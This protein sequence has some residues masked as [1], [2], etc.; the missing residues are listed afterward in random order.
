[1]SMM[2]DRPT[3]LRA[4]HAP[5]FWAWVKKHTDGFIGRNENFARAEKRLKDFAAGGLMLYWRRQA[6]YLAAA[7]LCGTFYSLL[8]AILCYSLCQITELADTLASRRVLAWTNGNLDQCKKYYRL[9]MLTSTLSS[10]AVAVFVFAVAR[11]EGTSSHF[12]PLFFLFAA[13]LFA[14]VNNHQIPQILTVRLLVYGMLFI[15]IPLRDIYVMSA[16]FT[17]PQ[18]LQF[19]T[20]IFVLYFVLD[21]SFIFLKMYR[22][23]LDQLDEVRVQRDAAQRAYKVKSEFVSVVSHE[24]RT[25]LTSINGALSLM[26]SGALNADPARSAEVLEIAYKNSLRLAA[27]IND[28]LDVQRLEHGGLIYNFD[29]MDIAD[30]IMESI[31]SINTYATP[32]RINIKFERPSDRIVTYVDKARMHQVF[33]NLLSNAIKFS[34]AGSEIE[35]SLAKVDRHAV[36]KVKDF[37]IGIPEDARERVFERFSQVDSSDQRSFGGSGLGLSIAQGIVKSHG[38]TIDFVSEMGS[39]TTFIVDLPLAAHLA[40]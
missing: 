10:A 32:K 20:S 17:S 8:V 1:M 18:W 7:L 23:G 6:I 21:C 40:A 14:A 16:P 33:D 12:T 26:R 31:T 25:P 36:I 2:S 9:L 37:G 4:S 30:L 15:F 34:N 3:N 27:L 28:I 24:L 11:L 13:G 19:M 39:G 35:V 38:G 5:D 29:N 22:T